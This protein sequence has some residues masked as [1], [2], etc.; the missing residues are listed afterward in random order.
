MSDQAIV[1]TSVII[2][3]EKINHAGVL[4]KIYSSIQLLESVK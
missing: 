3:L 1:D 2:A 4:Y